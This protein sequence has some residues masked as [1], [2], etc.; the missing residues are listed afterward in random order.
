MVFLIVLNFPCSLELLCLKE[1]PRFFSLAW[2]FAAEVATPSVAFY[3]DLRR[4]FPGGTAKRWYISQS[5]HCAN[6]ILDFLNL[7][8]IPAALRRC[9]DH[10]RRVV[11]SRVSRSARWFSETS[12]PQFSSLDSILWFTS[13]LRVPKLRN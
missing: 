4:A 5:L 8:S 2:S 12:A 10:L 3:I 1:T 9:I 13:T 11:D 7:G 6:T